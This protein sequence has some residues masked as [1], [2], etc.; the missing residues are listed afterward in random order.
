MPK[1]PAKI[2]VFDLD[3]TLGHFGQLGLVWDSI[4]QCC[5]EYKCKRPLFKEVMQMFPE[6][7][8]PGVIRMLRYLLGKKHMGSC[9]KVM[10]YT[11]N[12]GPREWA[13]QLRRYFEEVIGER[14]FDRIIAAFKVDGVR[15]EPHRTSHDK[16]VGDLISCTKISP[17]T[18]I[19][20][21]D[22]QHHPRMEHENVYYIRIKPYITTVPFLNIIHRL[23][24]SQVLRHLKEDCMER[25]SN[26][27]IRYSRIY[28]EDDI[29]K[30]EEELEVDKLVSKRVL[31]HI[32]EF[33][34]MHDRRLTR[35]R[36][37][38]VQKRS[39]RKSFSG[40]FK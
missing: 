16:S 38:K 21:I 6:Y 25:L 30:S 18:Q 11:N 2:V 31:Q 35:R 13:E 26:K 28:P 8:R 12:Q 10:I 17:D 7:Q 37:I 4:I 23:K 27:I 32:Q 9:H 5:D 22:D 39:T 29:P 19:C 33:F 36:R 15:V 34:K 1:I 20:F 24:Q 40:S 14:V 3:E